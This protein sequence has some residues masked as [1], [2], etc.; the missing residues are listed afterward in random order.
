GGVIRQLEANADLADGILSIGR[1][2]ALLPGATDVTLSGSATTTDRPQFDGQVT[3][4]SDDL[5][6]VLR[7]LAVDI[8]GLPA[9]RFR[10]LSLTTAVSASSARIEARDLAL[11]LDGSTITGGVVWDEGGTPPLSADLTVDRLDVDGL[12]PTH[13]NTN[14]GAVVPPSDANSKRPSTPAPPTGVGGGLNT[15]LRLR[16]NSLAF[17]GVRAANVV[18]D[19]TFRKDELQLRR[20]SVGNIAGASGWVSGV[21][22]G[23]TDTITFE[24]MN[25]EIDVPEPARLLPVFTLNVP[26]MARKIGTLTSYGRI[27]GT[28]DE[29]TIDVTLMTAGA[30]FN[31]TGTITMDPDNP[32]FSGKAGLRHPDLSVLLRALGVDYLPAGETGKTDIAASVTAGRDKLALEDLEGLLA[33][34]SVQG[35]LGMDLSAPR[36]AV[37]ADLTTEIIAL[38][39]LLPNNRHK[40]EAW[41]LLPASWTA[42][43]RPTARPTA[44]TRSGVVPASVHAR[45]PRTPFRLAELTAVDADARLR[46]KAIQY[47]NFELEN[48]ELTMTLENGVL[49][50][51]KLTGQLF[52][53]AFNATGR[54]TAAT[55]AAPTIQLK[56][57]LMDADLRRF[58]RAMDWQA[59]SS[60]RG[61]VNVTLASSG[62]SMSELISGLNGNTALSFRDVNVSD[63]ASTSPE[64]LLRV[65]KALDQLG[66]LLT[67]G[68]LSKSSADVTATTRIVDGVAKSDDIR[69]TY[70]WGTGD[71]QGTLDLPAWTIDASGKVRAAPNVWNQLL[72]RLGGMKPPSAIDF[73][74]RGP[75]DDADV[76]VNTRAL[77]LIVPVPGVGLIERGIGNVLDTLIPSPQN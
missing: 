33:G 70:F 38:D 5:R 14:T 8:Q 56:A 32:A 61:D 43:A 10:S 54:L 29:A 75:I 6:G 71:A 9:G 73:T 12:I 46:S 55:A 44:R 21:V 16:V 59:V 35:S 41:Q 52:G 45:W 25:F 18:L 47:D 26:K 63:N 65:L 68:K 19:G 15:D 23:L 1:I 66:V 42:T 4:E 72:S 20:L 3:V 64:P 48:A 60:G 49:A 77:S 30:E 53:G 31:T 37:T 62:Q 24:D 40:A 76:R 34:V 2:A 51:E 39:R 57:D 28:A 67:A 13:V 27:A 36:P 11:T 7:W 50:F 74:V 22:S 69:L 17:Q 58:S